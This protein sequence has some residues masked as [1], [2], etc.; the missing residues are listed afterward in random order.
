MHKKS[1]RKSY[2][3][4]FRHFQLTA[5]FGVFFGLHVAPSARIYVVDLD[6][7]ISLRQMNIY[8]STEICIDRPRSSEPFAGKMTFENAYLPY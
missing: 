1:H 8:A 7:L 6:A 5:E 3:L 4:R 2:F